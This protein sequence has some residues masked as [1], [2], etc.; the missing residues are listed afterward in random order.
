[1]GKVSM[2]NLVEKNDGKVA[3]CQP[4]RSLLREVIQW[5]KFF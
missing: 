5:A 1:M 4:G 2:T 3:W